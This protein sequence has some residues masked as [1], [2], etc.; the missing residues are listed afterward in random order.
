MKQRDEAR[1]AAAKQNPENFWRRGVPDGMR[2]ADA[3]AKWAEANQLADRFIQIMK[4]QGELPDEEIVEVTTLDDE[5][6]K[7]TMSVPVPV[8]DNGKA[9]RALR[10]AFVLAVGP[11][12]LQTKT[13]AIRIVLDFTRSKPESKTKLTVNPMAFLD[14]LDD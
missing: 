2:K 7:E 8:S 4:E 13:Q 10:E 11:T 12:N 5:G 1:I 3:D 6:N 9:E 14:D